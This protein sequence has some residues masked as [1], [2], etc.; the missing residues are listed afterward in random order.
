MKNIKNNI[1]LVII[2][3]GFLVSCSTDFLEEKTE[4][5][6]AT[7]QIYEDENL[8]RTYINGLYKL[9]VAPNDKDL[10]NYHLMAFIHGNESLFGSATDEKG[11]ENDLN[12]EYTSI[13]NT[14]NHCLKS[15]YSK[16]VDNDI[17][18]MIRYCNEYFD[19]VDNYE[20]LS[21][22]FKN[23]AKGQFYYFRG[24]LYFELV[25]LY[26][27]VPII[28]T[29][30][31][32]LDIEIPRSSSGEVINQIV[33][34]LDMAEAL[35]PTS[36]SGSDYGRVTN[37][38]ASALKG[39]VLLTWASP[40]FN[41]TDDQARWQ[42]AYDACKSA[43]DVCTA[44][45]KGLNPDWKNMW[46]EEEGNPEAITVVGYNNHDDS[47]RKN[48]ANERK[49]RS[50][51]AGG[52]G[53]ISPTKNIMDAFPMKDGTAY[54]PNSN[55][56]D[57]YKDRDP[58]FYNTFS[59]N[60]SIWPWSQEPEWKNWT[61]YWH[62][63]AG[64][65]PENSTEQDN[66]ATGVYLRKF[67]NDNFEYDDDD[68]FRYSG[69]DYMEFRF[70]E[71]V[72]NLA[73]AAVGIDNLSEAKGYLK[74][75]RER[76]GIEN[77]D[78]D[79]GLSAVSSRDQHFAACINERKVELAYEN[80]RFFDLR[81]WLLFNDNFGTVT[82]LNQTPIDGIRRQ[83]YYVV[84]KDY[85]GSDDPLK[86]DII[87]RD[88]DASNYPAGVTTYEEYVDYLYDNYFEVVVRDDVD[89]NGFSFTWYDEYYFFGIY[90][91]ALKKSPYLKQTQGWGNGFGA[92]VFDPLAE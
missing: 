71:V 69:T 73:E 24:L 52:D 18:G 61:Y 50:R 79:Y 47:D 12:K 81:R 57:F 5:N 19:N 65:D 83:G 42:R 87:D 22:E 88:A 55:L 3:T 28:T 82:Q 39:R 67:T 46:F 85:V 48:N 86:G 34:D 49:A 10:S 7:T 60:G 11:D 4:L 1:L 76:A 40:L 33:A 58:R 14:N 84:V 23:T 29:N 68:K 38:S 2:M 26:G 62:D 89:D 53:S 16:S 27:G 6:Q 37:L 64:G 91:D 74:K 15:I 20:G 30:K 17:W 45:G 21:D 31:T 80:K 44:A 66:N 70:A 8:S 75:I 92:G 90:E 13:L 72:L 9:V 78:G 35:L 25:R 56:N 63:E 51:A 32:E 41:R 54:D 77:N 59:Y 36:W 43:Y